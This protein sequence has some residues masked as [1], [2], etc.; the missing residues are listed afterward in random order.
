MHRPQQLPQRLPAR[1]DDGGGALRVDVAEPLDQHVDL[2]LDQPGAA[3]PVRQ[4][5]APVKLSRTPADC[6]RLPGPALGEHTAEV[7]RE[8][9]YGDDE[10]AALHEQGAVAGPPAPVPQGSFLG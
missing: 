8:A 1:A 4:L 2:A 3:A 9:G 6:G 7:L 5:G 10:I